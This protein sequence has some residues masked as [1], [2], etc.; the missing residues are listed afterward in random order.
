MC[1]PC[2]DAACLHLRTCS[3]YHRHTQVQRNC[4]PTQPLVQAN[5][6]FAC[7]DSIIPKEAAYVC[8]QVNVQL[9]QSS[10]LVMSFG[11]YNSHRDSI[12]F[13]HATTSEQWSYFT[14]AYVGSDKHHT[15]SWVVDK[16]WTMSI[17]TQCDTYTDNSIQTIHQISVTLHPRAAIKKEVVTIKDLREACHHFHKT[18]KDILKLPTFH[19]VPKFLF[20]LSF[21]SYLLAPYH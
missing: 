4:Q 2:S 8:K 3:A 19:I 18:V 13:V 10:N 21:R 7:V 20:V 11:M 15:T 12:Y 17:L 1:L 14:D 9:Q 16:L 5:I 6:I